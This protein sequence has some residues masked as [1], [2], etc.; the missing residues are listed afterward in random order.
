MDA[1]LG[2][3]ADVDVEEGFRTVEKKEGGWTGGGGCGGGGIV[4]G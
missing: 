3:D 2:V 4:C 1:V